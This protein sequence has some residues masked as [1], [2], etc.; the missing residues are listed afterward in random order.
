[1]NNLTSLKLLVDSAVQ[2]WAKGYTDKGELG[3]AVAYAVR[4]GKRLRPIML[5]TGASLVGGDIDKAMPYAIAIELIHNYS[6][7][8]DDLPCMDNDDLRR[9]EL[10]VH[11][12]YGEWLALLVGDALLNSA[13]EILFQNAKDERAIN[14]SSILA[15][16]SGINGMVYGQFLDLS[17]CNQLEKIFL[18]KTGKLFEGALLAGA[19]LFTDDKE[20]LDTLVEFS[21]RFGLAFQIAD[22]LDDFDQGIIFE[23]ELNYAKLYGR[24]FAINE[25]DSLVKSAKNLADKFKNPQLLLELL[26]FFG[27]YI[28]L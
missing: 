5:L 10:T 7:V 6:L 23:E 12:K 19:T 16:S 26:G 3:E 8:H 2:N 11:K 25:L 13:F 28:K 1:M 24:D 20:I 9:G 14:A 27:K 17:H 18:Y 21:H 22:D 4:G 15:K